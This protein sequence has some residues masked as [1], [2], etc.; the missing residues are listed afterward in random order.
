MKVFSYLCIQK[1]YKLKQ[2][3]TSY[4]TKNGISSFGT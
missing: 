2:K 3:Y 1:T 4:R